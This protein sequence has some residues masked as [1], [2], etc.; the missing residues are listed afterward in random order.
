MLDWFGNSCFVLLCGVWFLFSDYLLHLNG[1]SCFL[2]YRGAVGSGF[3]AVSAP[4]LIG[5]R[6]EKYL[7]DGSGRHAGIVAISRPG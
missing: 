4:T 1:F 5:L 6:D 2:L 7:L 3:G